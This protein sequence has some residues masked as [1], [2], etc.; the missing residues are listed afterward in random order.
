M[1]DVAILIRVSKMKIYRMIGAGELSDIRI[2][3]LY[4]VRP[5]TLQPWLG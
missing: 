1:G 2:D 3:S 5:S 4:R